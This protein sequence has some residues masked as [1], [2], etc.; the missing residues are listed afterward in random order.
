VINNYT[1]V[2]SNIG[3]NIARNI[4]IT[5]MVPGIIHNPFNFTIE[6]D[7]LKYSI[8]ELAP[9]E[10]KQIS[11][12]FY[13]PN[14]ATISNTTISYNNIELILNLNSTT[15]ESHP[16]DVY[17]SAPIDYLSRNPYIRTIE[18]YCN[19]TTLAPDIDE[20]FNLSIY[21]KNTGFDGIMIPNLS[22]SFNDQ[23]GDLAPFG[24]LNLN[25]SKIVYNEL[26]SS[27]ISVKKIGWKGYYYPSVNYFSCLEE[28]TIQIASSKPVILGF[29]NFS[30]IKSV[31]RDQIEIGDIITVNITV[32]NTGNICAKNIT[33]SDAIGF[34]NIEFELISGS[35]I[36]TTTSLQPEEEITFSYKIQATKQALIR[37]KP[38]S[39]EYFYLQKVIETSNSIEVKVIL[40]EEV[41]ILFVLGPALVA[42]TILTIFI[43][44]T[45]KYKANK[46]ELQRNELLLF[47]V[48]H[49]D[50]VLKVENTLRDQLVS[51]SKEQSYNKKG[52]EDRGEL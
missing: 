22:L 13:I 38:A 21:I 35:L 19:S 37:L 18:I 17:F 51:L 26:I 28:N 30:I 32:T 25:T 7:Y 40:P 52:I 36:F 1:L 4:N 12:S 45:K 44:K 33:I 11:F 2:F 15:L 14:T 5:I 34:T 24:M 27:T 46:Y 48:S 10:K 23:Y 50:S 8:V 39:I 43:W 49:S 3:S 16:N 47:K 41:S 42:L 31:N 20:T 6:K 29:L 9:A